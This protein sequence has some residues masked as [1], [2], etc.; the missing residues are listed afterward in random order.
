[1]SFPGGVF[2]K[3][4]FPGKEYLKEENREKVAL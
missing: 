1:L 2:Y 4:S 3:K